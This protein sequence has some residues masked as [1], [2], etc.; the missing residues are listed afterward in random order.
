[1]AYSCKMMHCWVVGRARA[2]KKDIEN[3]AVKMA[4]EI[5]ARCRCTRLGDTK[6]KRSEL[7]GDVP[8]AL[9]NR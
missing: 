9:V 1:M 8:V 5:F 7:E 3:H 4:D 6:G 2:D